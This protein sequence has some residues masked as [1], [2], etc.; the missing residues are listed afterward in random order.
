MFFGKP[1]GG[2]PGDRFRLESK[3][4]KLKEN[5]KYQSRME[6]GPTVGEIVDQDRRLHW[7]R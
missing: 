3:V 6:M 2:N 7:H 4:L 1:V 5:I